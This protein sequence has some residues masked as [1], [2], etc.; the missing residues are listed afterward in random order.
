MITTFKLF[1]KSYFMSESE[2]YGSYE[3]IIHSDMNSIK[4]WFSKRNIDYDKYLDKLELPVAF[5][6][7]IN[8]KYRGQGYGNILYSKFEN[9]CYEND[10][11]CI[12]LES[13]RAEHQSEGFNLDAWY[14]SLGFEI[15]GEEG[16]NSIMLN[17]L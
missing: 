7:N 9:E 5:L 6:N 3:G 11:K 15:I 10:A 17:I 2:D 4:N 12:L 16:G 14:K 8:V 1:E 13:D